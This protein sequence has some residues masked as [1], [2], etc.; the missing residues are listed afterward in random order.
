LLLSHNKS[1]GLT[2]AASF[3]AIELTICIH[4]EY[5]KPSTKCWKKL[6]VK[7]CIPW[8]FKASGCIKKATT[9]IKLGEYSWTPGNGG[10]LSSIN[11]GNFRRVL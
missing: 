11:F 4:Y 10:Y 2:L 7:I 8:L 9:K 1:I 5:S 3:R 6:G